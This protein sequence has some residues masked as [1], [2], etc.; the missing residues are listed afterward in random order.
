M[1][2]VDEDDDENIL[3]ASSNSIFETIML[4]NNMNMN[5]L[6]K[7]DSNWL[8]IINDNV[9]EIDFDIEMKDVIQ[10]NQPGNPILN[11]DCMWSGTCDISHPSKKKI[12]P[13]SIA[14]ILKEYEPSS[15]SDSGKSSTISL[16]HYFK[17]KT[18]LTDDDLRSY[19]EVDPS[20]QQQLFN[21]MECP[22]VPL[23]PI[24][25]FPFKLPAS[26]PSSLKIQPVFLQR[27]VSKQYTQTSQQYTQIYSSS[28]PNSSLEMNGM[29][30]SFRQCKIDEAQDQ[31]MNYECIEF[32]PDPTQCL[33]PDQPLQ[34]HPQ[35][36]VNTEPFLVCNYD[37]EMLPNANILYNSKPAKTPKAKTS[38]KCE[39]KDRTLGN[40]IKKVH[41]IP[42]KYIKKAF[43]NELANEGMSME[44]RNMHNDMERQRR[45]AMRN[46]YV[47]LKAEIPSIRGS[48]RVPKV[49]ILR[50][51][52]LYCHEVQ[53]KEKLLAQLRVKNKQLLMK[54]ETLGQPPL[55]KA[56][57]VGSMTSSASSYAGSE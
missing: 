44:K 6:F 55:K 4:N 26:V 49:S 34:Y 9:P 56:F 43:E 11:H 50:A 51:A 10:S 18:P 16:S 30:Y 12:K 7:P 15:E 29:N 33:I 57:S 47:D 2:T 8:A 32:F 3:N 41:K 42:K 52:S 53:D 39:A 37:E 36:I 31:P 13:L 5:E 20:E 14:A 25:P 48:D 40:K 46:L 19:M 17:F 45:I 24:D 22:T 23:E 35:M 28:Q 38:I 21:L 54:L 27:Q 1:M